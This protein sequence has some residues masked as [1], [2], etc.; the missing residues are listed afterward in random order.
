M[1]RRRRYPVLVT[2]GL[3]LIVACAP[4]APLQARF[5]SPWSHFL[6]GDGL[7]AGFDTARVAR[8]GDTSDVWIRF[9]YAEPQSLPGGQSPPYTAMEVE[10]AVDC[11]TGSTSLRRLIARNAAGDTVA[12]ST[13]EAPRWVTFADAGYGE[14]VFAEL[15]RALPR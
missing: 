11:T 13:I 8:L 15:C 5:T 6:D 14:R 10:H 3:G 2:V 1:L 9:Q 4:P 7:A 12:H